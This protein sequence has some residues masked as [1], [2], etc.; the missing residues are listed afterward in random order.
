LVVGLDPALAGLLLRA[1]GIEPQGPANGVALDRLWA[2]LEDAYTSPP[3]LGGYLWQTEERIQFSG[4]KPFDQDC[5]LLPSISQAI[6]RAKAAEEMPRL[7]RDSGE[8]FGER[9]HRAYHVLR[10]R[11]RALEGDL[12]EAL[13]AEEIERKANSL[14]ANLGAV[15]LG[16]KSVEIPDIY[17]SSGRGRVRV[18]IDRNKTAAE[19]AAQLLRTAKR[20]R[21]R[22]V[23]VPR[24][25]AR[26]AGQ[27]AEV[28]QMLASGEKASASTD[29]WLSEQGLGCVPGATRKRGETSAHPRRYCTSTGWI[30]WVGRNNRENDLLSHRLAAQ[31]DIWFH[32]HGYP[33]AHVVLRREGRR[34]EP[35]HQTLMEAASLAAYWSKGKTARKVPVVYTL[36]KYVSKPKGGAPGQALV[37]REKT[38]MV[39]P[40]L[41]QEEGDR[42]QR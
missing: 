2:L 24:L 10:R 20:Y 40:G 34:E 35:S 15:P 37:K 38:M 9:L 23:V 27:L 7:A 31:N 14:L 8:D 41:L 3:D 22:R 13:K 36:V 6:L 30:V 29:T 26:V 5:E 19:T 25:L 1:S 18:E 21:Q 11:Q 16:E 32:A 39:E 4:L 42:G 28:E 12:A 17:D 33:G